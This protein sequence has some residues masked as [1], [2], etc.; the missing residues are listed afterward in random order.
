MQTII[1]QPKE[2]T[3]TN[4]ILKLLKQLKLKARFVSNEELEDAY[5]AKLIDEGVKEGGE[6]P[7]AEIKK[8]LR[9]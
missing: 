7:L 6:V 2:E 5:L 3:Q 9:Q 1:I 4:L 8:K